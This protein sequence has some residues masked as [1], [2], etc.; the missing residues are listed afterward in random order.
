MSLPPSGENY[1][2]KISLVSRKAADKFG[3]VFVSEGEV[4][5]VE[6]NLDEYFLKCEVTNTGNVLTDN[7]RFT[8]RIDSLGTFV[9]AVPN[10]VDENAKYNYLIQFQIQ[11]GAYFSKLFRFELSE[12]ILQEDEKFGEVLVMVCRGREYILRENLSSRPLRFKTPWEAFQER[13]NDFA[14]NAPLGAGAGIGFV[15]NGLPGELVEESA[16][17]QNWSPTGP[18]PIQRHLSDILERVALPATSGG[19]LR[20]FYMDADADPTAAGFFNLTTDEFGRLPVADGDR[21]IISPEEFLTA[22]EQKDKTVITENKT[23]KNQIILRGGSTKGSLPMNYVRYASNLEHAKRRPEFDNATAY[24]VGALVKKTI[25]AMIAG[26]QD[27]VR[28]FQCLVQQ[29]IGPNP[30]VETNSDWLEDFTPYPNF[31]PQGTYEVGDIVAF[32]PA[33]TTIFYQCNTNDASLHAFATGLDDV[34]PPDINANFTAFLEPN[35]R[36][37][38]SFTEFVPFSP[39]TNN[40]DDWLANMCEGPP[41]GYRGAFVDWNFVRVNYDRFNFDNEFERITLKWVTR[42]SNTPPTGGEIFHGQ[43]ILVGASGTVAGWT[44]AGN[45]PVDGEGKAVIFVEEKLAQFDDTPHPISGLGGGFWR[46]SANPTEDDIVIDLSTGSIL[47]Y[48]GTYP[49]GS[50]GNGWSITTF[51]AKTSPIHHVKEVFY[52]KTGDGTVN[53]ALKFRFGFKNLLEGGSN[54]NNQSRGAWLN[55]WFPFP[56]LAL[57]TPI[58]TLQIGERYGGVT[59]PKGDFDCNNLYSSANDQIGWNR[60]LESEDLGKVSGIAMKLKLD[61]VSPGGQSVNVGISNMP[62]KFWAVDLF[63]RVFTFDFTLDRINGW[64]TVI[65]PFGSTSSKS[66]HFNRVSEAIDILGWLPFGILNVDQKEFTGVTFDWRHVKV[67]GVQWTYPYNDAGAYKNN[68][69][70]TVYNFALTLLQAF[71]DGARTI[72]ESLLRFDIEFA[73]LSISDLRFVKE[74]YVN[75]EDA[76]VSDARTELINS[77]G[78]FDYQTA[79]F[80]AQAARERTKFFPQT[81]HVRSFGDVRLRV[82]RRFLLQGDKVPNGEQEMV[83][84]QVK[85]IIDGTSYKTEI[86][87]KRK[88]VLP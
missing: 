33:A 75:S 61:L 72:N 84:Q 16:L 49:T 37:N 11:Q 67:W 53:Q 54:I 36:T 74:L 31:L 50:W 3:I 63:D 55:F 52:D 65:I 82:G 27:L 83:V 32:S 38:S 40:A 85:H 42:Q 79:K 57:T 17:K 30:I 80:T 39:W 7:A 24:D 59:S 35:G 68:P 8:F 62:F 77:E 13:V 43:R 14:A 45:V 21:V 48:S 46:M 6:N 47:V 25:P 4:S 71:V 34:D 87:A 69:T 2:R 9:R 78:E 73:D 64:Q 76:N 66:L 12:A 22:A 5:G 26:K 23:F 88:F 86:E 51:P 60:G 18:L 29:T 1:V 19:V 81:I 44:L 15:T 58:T 20:D 28:Y 10:L 56:R 70:Q 41:A